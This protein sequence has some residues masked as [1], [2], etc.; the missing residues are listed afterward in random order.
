MSLFMRE[1]RERERERGERSS[2]TVGFFLLF[3]SS[4]LV[5]NDF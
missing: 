4:F 1:E 2:P 5:E 3:L